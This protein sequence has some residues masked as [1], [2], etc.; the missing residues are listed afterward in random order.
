VQQLENCNCCTDINNYE[1]SEN[2]KNIGYY[3]ENGNGV[4]ENEKLYDWNVW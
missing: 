1:N 4:G 3:M 2:K